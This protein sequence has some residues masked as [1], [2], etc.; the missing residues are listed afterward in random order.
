[1]S[2]RCTTAIRI[3][4]PRPRLSEIRLKMTSWAQIH[5][6]LRGWGGSS[7]NGGEEGLSYE[8]DSDPERSLS[9]VRGRLKGAVVQ[10]LC[11]FGMRHGVAVTPFTAGFLFMLVARKCQGPFV[12]V[13]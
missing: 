6:H 2:L 8:L 13:A 4:D 11:V 12:G 1:M 3:R 5:A 7:T 10:I 9:Q